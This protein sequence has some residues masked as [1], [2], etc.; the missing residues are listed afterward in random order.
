MSS[1]HEVGLNEN[2]FAKKLNRIGGVGMNATYARG[3]IND[4]VRSSISDRIE[5]N[6]AVP[7]VHFARAPTDDLANSLALKSPHNR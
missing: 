7:Q 1:I 3:R 5:R 4:D 6:L 2:V